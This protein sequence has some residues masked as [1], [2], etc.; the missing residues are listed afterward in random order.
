MIGMSISNHI[1]FAAAM[2]GLSVFTTAADVSLVGEAKLTGDVVAMDA[3]GTITLASPVSKKPLLLNGSQVRSVDFEIADKNFIAPDQ[4]V[5]LINGDVLPVRVEELDGSKIL[6]ASP[7]LGSFRIPREFVDSVRFG[8]VP[9]RMIY[10]GSDSMDGWNR[11]SGGARNWEIKD[12]RYLAT[13]QGMVSRDLVLPEKFILRFQLNWNRHPNF[14]MFF[15]GPSIPP[16]ER[17]NRYYLQF[18]ASGFEIRREMMGKTRYAPIVLLSRSPDEIPESTLKVEIRV[19]RTSGLIQLFLNG[20][21]EGRYTDP[22]PD[23]P[24]GGHIAMISQAPQ[25]SEQA[26]TNLEILEWDDRADR[27][28][29]EDRGD[30]KTDSLIGRFGER[31]GGSLAQIKRGDSGT[32]YLFKSDFQKDMI[33]L[34]E[35]EVSTIF[36][37]ASEVAAKRKK[38]DGRILRLRGGGDMRVSTCVFGPVTVVAVHP[39][40]G[41]IKIDRAGITSIER[42][43]I[44]KAEPVEDR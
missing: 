27:H 31:F 32:A 17:A 2:L 18:S 16:N 22:V 23:I 35:E 26:L 11:D 1:A 39:L 21:L 44:P 10:S 4:R 30:G 20:Q 37:A 8:M 24:D 38:G 40:L 5:E 6:V 12:G 34:P 9:E 13:G 29:S 19:D 42:E 25:E 33:E 43:E 41:E 3:S 15:A 28:R 36:F 7:D 14:R